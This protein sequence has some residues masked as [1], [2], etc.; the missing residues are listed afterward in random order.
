MR[1]VLRS[2]RRP[3]RTRPVAVIVAAVVGLGGLGGAAGVV[4]GE[5]GAAGATEHRVEGRHHDR[6]DGP[7][8]RV[9]FDDGGVDGQPD[10]PR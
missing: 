8:G 5:L 10:A 1:N 4:L 7:D 3:R 9:R 6:L 2:L